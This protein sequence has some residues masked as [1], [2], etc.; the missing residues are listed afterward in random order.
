MQWITIEDNFIVR[1][2]NYEPIVSPSLLKR[3]DEIWRSEK[4]SNSHLFDGRTL[5]VFSISDTVLECFPVPYRFFFAQQN[6]VAIRELLQLRI[7]AVS[8]VL[9]HD[10]HIAVGKRSNS[11]T[12]HRGLFELVPSGSLPASV[13]GGGNV[14][15]MEHLLIELEE[16]IGLSARKV[17][18]ITPFALV[19]D[20]KAGVV[21][22][23]CKMR[24][25]ATNIQNVLDSFTPSEY[26]EVRMMTLSQ[27]RQLP[28]GKLVPVSALIAQ[29]L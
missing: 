12:E 20:D 2:L 3:I 16:E 19:Q 28:V 5:C 6:D 8:G 10:D 14:N 15:Y 4:D 21:D 27:I 1:C 7:A 13:D 17:D 9:I 22:I 25:R 11:V 23:C 26:A 24:L 18:K 29:R